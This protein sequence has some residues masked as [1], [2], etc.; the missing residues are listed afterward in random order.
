MTIILGLV[1]VVAVLAAITAYAARDVD[2]PVT[3]SRSRFLSAA[4]PVEQAP[5]TPARAA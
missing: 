5:F 2:N 3:G 1:A 4:T